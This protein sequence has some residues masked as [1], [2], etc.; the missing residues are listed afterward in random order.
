VKT[1]T[2]YA[3]SALVAFAFAGCQAKETG[4]AP[5]AETAA[6]EN[7]GGSAVAPEAVTFATSDGWD[8]HATCWNA[9]EGE[10]AAILLHMLPADRHSYDDFGSKLAAAGFNVLALDSRGHGE[11]VNH[12]GKVERYNDFGGDEYRSSVADVAAAKTF[13]AGKGAD[14][15]RTVIV[16]ASI[17]ANFA[18]NYGAPDADVRAVVLLSPGLN[19]HGVTTADAMSAYGDRPAYLVASE[20]DSY[21]ADSVGKL[22]EIAGKAELALFKNAGHGTDIFRAE[23]SLADTLVT[24]LSA[25]VKK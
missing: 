12:D 25:Q 21:A 14:T 2:M 3:A 22:H 24:W 16:G 7:E 11:S 9:G 19:Y 18:L 5:A 13:L 23:P 8:I 1:I 10:P 20:E 17:G 4:E 15:S 6:T